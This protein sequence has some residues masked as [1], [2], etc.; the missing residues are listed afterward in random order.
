[1]RLL[2]SC[3][4]YSFYNLYFVIFS[5]TKSILLLETLKPSHV[6]VASVFS[7]GMGAEALSGSFPAKH[8][9]T[10]KHWLKQ[11]GFAVAAVRVKASVVHNI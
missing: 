11:T 7:G 4:A 1:M 6:C 10:R 3:S 8:S 9:V 5:R 2:H